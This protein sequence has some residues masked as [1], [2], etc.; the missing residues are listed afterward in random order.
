M[1]SGILS[2]VF[3]MTRTVSKLRLSISAIFLNCVI[4]LSTRANPS[5]EPVWNSKP[6]PWGDLEVRA[7]YLEA[8]DS[9]IATVPKPNTVVSWMFPGATPASLKQLFDRAKLDEVFQQELLDPKRMTRQDGVLAVLPS[10]ARLEAMTIEQR[11]I[12]YSE[13]SKSSLNEFKKD[14]VFIPDG[15]VDDWLRETGLRP[16]IQDLIRKLTWHCGHAL[17]FSDIRVLMSHAQSDAEL[18]EIFKTATRVRTLLVELKLSPHADPKPLVDYWSAGNPNSDIIPML[19]SAVER[20][21]VTSID[22]LHVLPPL[23]R[24]RLYTYP[25]AELAARGRM[26]DC[27]WTSLNFFNLTRQDYFLDTRLASSHVIADYSPVQPP[28]HYGDVLFFQNDDSQVIHSCVFIADDIVFTKNGEN[29]LTPWILMKLG[30]VKDLYL[31]GPEWR[32]QGYRRKSSTI[33]AS[34]F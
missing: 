21:N 31:R 1:L 8:P 23:A 19:E 22:I 29:A 17:A 26:P 10:T 11:D 9:L 2:L 14:P 3:T 12:I 28:Y 33:Q 4:A 25:T 7:M 18:L 16:E 30:D 34:L 32:I 13:L 5:P 20:E 6:G 27:H 24:R 15:N